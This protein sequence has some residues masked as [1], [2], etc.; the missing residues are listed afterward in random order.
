MSRVDASAPDQTE[1]DSSMMLVAAK[2]DTATARINW[3]RSESE[4]SSAAVNR[5]DS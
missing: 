2:P 1:T 3:L 4:A 5:C